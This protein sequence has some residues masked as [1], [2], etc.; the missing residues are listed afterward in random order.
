MLMG[1]GGVGKTTLA[2]AIAVELA[3]RGHAVHLTTS[4]PAAHLADTLDGAVDQPEGQPHRSAGRNRALPRARAGHQGRGSR[5]AGPG[6]AR[7]RPALALHRGDRRVPGV[8]AHHPRGGQVVRRDGHRAHRP[9]AAAAR[10]HRRVSPRHRAATRRHGATLHDA[11][12]AA[13]GSE[14][15][16]GPAGDAGRDHAGA[17]GRAAAGRPAPRRHRAV[18]VGHQRQPGHGRGRRS[19]LLRL[20]AQAEVAQ[21]EA[22]RKQHAARLAVIPLLAEEPV[23]VERLLQLVQPESAPAAAT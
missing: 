19:P 9:H 22:V 17:G 1:K 8:L 12:D 6:A 13:A 16:Q 4:D 18:G 11:D 15:D 20:R 2:A 7:R 23:G 5:C 10:R 3:R 14:A 21:I